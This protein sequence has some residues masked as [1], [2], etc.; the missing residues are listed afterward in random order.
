MATG[1]PEGL[2]RRVRM[3]ASMDVAVAAATSNTVLA[4]R[5][6]AEVRRESGDSNLRYRVALSDAAVHCGR[7]YP[8]FRMHD[9][10]RETLSSLV[11]APFDRHSDDLLFVKRI[12]ARPVIMFHVEHGHCAV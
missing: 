5:D 2:L 6:V 11:D 1:A 3:W 12:R 9:V 10:P 8:W 4:A 7:D